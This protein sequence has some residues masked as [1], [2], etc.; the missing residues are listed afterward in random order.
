M[1]CIEEAIENCIGSKC[2]T[3]CLREFGSWFALQF[4]LWFPAHF[5]SDKKTRFSK[6]L[7]E[8]SPSSLKLRSS[9]SCEVAKFKVA[10]LQ[11][12]S[13]EVAKFKVAKF[14]SRRS[15]KAMKFLSREVLKLQSSSF[16]A[17]KFVEFKVAKF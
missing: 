2:F 14:E 12:S 15:S 10:K 7:W 1:V 5:T 8:N 6:N 9:S 16:K 3:H 13:F 11:S 17:A 4:A